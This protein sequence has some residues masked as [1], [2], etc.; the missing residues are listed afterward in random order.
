MLD[1][2]DGAPLPT[3]DL[4]DTPSVQMATELLERELFGLEQAGET[5]C[6]VIYGIGSGR[7]GKA[8]HEI[9]S[10]NPL[11]CKWQIEQS[12]GSVVVLM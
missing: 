11:V 5:V 4:H 7:L 2:Y 12:G 3:I 9:L 6:R 1:L 10:K 8:V